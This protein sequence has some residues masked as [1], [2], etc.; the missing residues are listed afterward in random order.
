M[1]NLYIYFCLLLLAAS[2]I[3]SGDKPLPPYLQAADTLV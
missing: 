3:G 1:R 2:C